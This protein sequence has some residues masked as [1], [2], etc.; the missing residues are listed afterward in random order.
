M[1]TSLFHTQA[2]AGR[3]NSASPSLRITPNR[4]LKILKPIDNCRLPVEALTSSSPPHVFGDST[5]CNSWSTRDI[6]RTRSKA[7][8]A[9]RS[10]A[11]SS[12][13]PPKR[14]LI[15]VP[16]VRPVYTKRG[17][18]SIFLTFFLLNA[19]NPI[20]PC[21]N[22]SFISKRRKPCFGSTESCLVF[23]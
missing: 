5:F 14:Q 15:F 16:V 22:I 12:F 18:L 2:R 4:Q 13:S 3:H 6:G 23:L 19:T 9:G 17:D 1:R 21:Y 10:P 11:P 20:T 8:Q 7:S